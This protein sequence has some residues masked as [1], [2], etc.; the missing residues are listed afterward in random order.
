M[1]NPEPFDFAKYQRPFRNCAAESNGSEMQAGNLSDLL[2]QVSQNSAS[3]IDGLIGELQRVREKLQADGE[4]IRREIEEYAELSQQV[5][6]LTNIIS[7]S[8]GKLRPSLADQRTEAKQ[9]IN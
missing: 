8:V 6:Q 1:T 4:R 5:M 9:T 3:E 2:N 7:E